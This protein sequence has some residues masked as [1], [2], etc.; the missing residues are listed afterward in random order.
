MED[1]PSKIN[2]PAW[3]GMANLATLHK[4]D[5]LDLK[6]ENIVNKNSQRENWVQLTFVGHLDRPDQSL[7]E[8]CVETKNHRKIVEIKNQE[9]MRENTGC[10]N[11]F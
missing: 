2:K 7:E 1:I 9:K 4:N 5:P 11:K 3:I 6:L 10:P 8:W